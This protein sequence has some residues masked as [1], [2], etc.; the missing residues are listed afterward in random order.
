[1][2]VCL[3]AC[4]CLPSLVVT[5]GEHDLLERFKSV[6]PQVAKLNLPCPLSVT[7]RTFMLD[8]GLL[9]EHEAEQLEAEAICKVRE[10][11]RADGS[12]PVINRLG[13]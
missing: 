4:V 11:R 7:G 12:G 13:G 2:P 5:E 1:M 3:P 9:D 8:R 10:G 6:L